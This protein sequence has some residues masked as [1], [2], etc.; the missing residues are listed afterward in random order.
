MYVLIIDILNY[1]KGSQGKENMI[2]KQELLNIVRLKS[3]LHLNLCMLC[4]T[5]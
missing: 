5:K 3:H 2:K 1:D 4:S